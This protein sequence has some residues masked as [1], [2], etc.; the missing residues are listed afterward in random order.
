MRWGHTFEMRSKCVGAT[1]SVIR[2]WGCVHGVRWG[3][4]VRVGCVGVT[5]SVVG[6]ASTFGWWT[7]QAY[8]CRMRRSSD[9]DRVH[10]SRC[11]YG[12]S[13]G[14]R[15]MFHSEEFGGPLALRRG[16]SSAFSKSRGNLGELWHDHFALNSLALCTTSPPAAMNGVQFFSV[17]TIGSHSWTFLAKRPSDSAGASR[18]GC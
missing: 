4:G 15:R 10:S 13:S 14:C 16:D 5:P 3:C 1:P 9:R 12:L 17:T 11:R 7:H 18:C 2:A 6:C 8:H